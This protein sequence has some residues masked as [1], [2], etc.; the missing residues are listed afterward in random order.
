MLY[1]ACR[2]Q[3]ELGCDLGE[4]DAA[5][6]CFVLSVSCLDVEIFLVLHPLENIVGVRHDNCIVAW[7]QVFFQAP[8]IH[9]NLLYTSLE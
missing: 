5:C 9:P 8:V 7:K 4:M 6:T 3:I 1:F 2:E